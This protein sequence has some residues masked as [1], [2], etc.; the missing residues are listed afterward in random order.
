MIC[1]LPGVSHH[2]QRP[3]GRIVSGPG[4]HRFDALDDGNANRRL[5]RTPHY[6]L[7]ARVEQKLR[8]R[9]EAPIRLHMT[10]SEWLFALSRG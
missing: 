9:I 8:R 7:L 4:C 1:R 2:H 6:Q 3:D 10:L 5:D